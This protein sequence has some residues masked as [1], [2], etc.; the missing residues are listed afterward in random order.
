MI[1]MGRSAPWRISRS[2]HALIEAHL[3]RTGRTFGRVIRPP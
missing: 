3:S 1:P 2:Q